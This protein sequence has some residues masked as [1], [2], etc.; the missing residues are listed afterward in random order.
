MRKIF[1][2]LTGVFICS[3]AAIVTI[4]AHAVESYSYTIDCL[5]SVATAQSRVIQPGSIVTLVVN[6]CDT[7]QRM[8]PGMHTWTPLS[9]TDVV[10]GSWT[11][12]ETF[13]AVIGE[14]GTEE[15]LLF[16]QLADPSLTQT[17][18]ALVAGPLVPNP[19]GELLGTESI[20]IAPNAGTMNISTQGLT[21][22]DGSVCAMQDGAHSF[23]TT[24]I[25]VTQSGTYTFRVTAVMQGT[26]DPVI[27]IYS[28]FDPTQPAANLIACNDDARRSGYLESNPQTYV[29]NLF[30]EIIVE[31]QPGTYILMGTT[32]DPNDPNTGWTF[33][34]DQSTSVE[35]WGPPLPP[36]VAPA[37]LAVTG[38]A[39]SGILPWAVFIIVLGVGW[40]LLVRN[41]RQTRPKKQ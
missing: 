15:G 40:N 28:A 27:G 18:F 14:E 31:L 7:V 25:D 5:D 9:P 33:T 35:M 23:G 41:S 3:S 4:P 1:Y 21:G 19:E 10:Q 24:I 34:T 16:S 17:Y 13:T 29:N 2:L 8:G 11:A 36:V 37:S 20:T 32:F 12:H 39:I 30:S 26:S 6:N 38:S 22:S